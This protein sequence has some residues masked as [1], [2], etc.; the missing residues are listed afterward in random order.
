MRVFEVMG[1]NVR[2]TLELPKKA[3]ISQIQNLLCDGT[4]SS[5]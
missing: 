2:E 1:W 3:Q 4:E 5:G